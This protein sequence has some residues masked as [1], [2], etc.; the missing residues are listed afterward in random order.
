LCLSSPA[1]QA[2]AIHSV[3]CRAAIDRKS[4][5]HGKIWE[6]QAIEP[7]R[8]ICVDA[9]AAF[10]WKDFQPWPSRAVKAF[11][12]Q[13]VGVP[14]KIILKAYKT[15]AANSADQLHLMHGAIWL[16]EDLISSRLPFVHQSQTADS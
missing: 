12:P 13:S 15:P 16:D 10:I 5:T 4:D 7:K 1:Q 14:A 8:R 3:R 9:S 6:A 11:P 2:A